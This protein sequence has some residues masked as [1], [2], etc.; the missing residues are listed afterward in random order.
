MPHY[1]VKSGGAAEICREPG[2]THTH[3]HTHARTHACI[4]THPH[5]LAHIRGFIEEAWEVFPPAAPQDH[6]Q[7]EEVNRGEITAG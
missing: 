4:C 7:G 3:T 5:T 1:Q 6:A 2:R